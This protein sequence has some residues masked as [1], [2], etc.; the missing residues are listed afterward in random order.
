MT[1]QWDADANLSGTSLCGYFEPAGFTFEEVVARLK[2][3]SG[4]QPEQQGDGEKTSVEFVGTFDGAVFTLY[5]YK[6]DGALHIGSHPAFDARPVVD[7]EA[8]KDALIAIVRATPPSTYSAVIP[9]E[10]GGGRH[11]FVAE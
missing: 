1:I 2:T 3:A 5:D 6:G 10:Y 7:V 9:P 4:Q 8:L 11:Q